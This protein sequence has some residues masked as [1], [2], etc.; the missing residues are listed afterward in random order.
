MLI[1]YDA[2][3]ITQIEFEYNNLHLLPWQEVKH[4][5]E[6][7]VQVY[8]YRNATDN[9]PFKNICDVALT[10]LVLPFSN[11]EVERIFSQLNIVKNKTRNKLSTDMVNSLLC[12]RYGLKRY[13]KCC[14]DYELP[15]DVLKIIGTNQA[16]PQKY[17]NFELF[18]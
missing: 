9:N 15:E 7:W 11:A 14:H 1:N 4:T 13:D 18:N 16:Y 3:K 12:I 10:L 17:E 8:S 6:F 2:A 5:V